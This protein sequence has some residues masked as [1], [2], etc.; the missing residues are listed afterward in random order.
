VDTFP[1][2]KTGASAQFGS[3]REVRFHT[4]VLRFVDGT[5][6]RMLQR[7][8]D[9]HWNL[10]FD[11]LTEEEVRT[12]ADFFHYHQGSVESFRFEDPWTGEVVESCVFA[13]DEVEFQWIGPNRARTSIRIRKVGP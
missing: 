4:K 11:H 1:K 3:S 9:V 7:R 13:T 6:Q 8:A 12:I 10:E 5:E 2:L